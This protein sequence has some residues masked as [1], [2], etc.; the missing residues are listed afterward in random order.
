VARLLAGA[1]LFRIFRDDFSE[2]LR[3]AA[4][5]PTGWRFSASLRQRAFHESYKLL[6]TIGDGFVVVHFFLPRVG[7]PPE[8]MCAFGSGWPTGVRLGV[9][10]QQTL[11]DPS[12]MRFFIAAAALLFSE[13]VRCF[14]VSS[15][16]LADR[17]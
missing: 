11:S 5:H 12:A 13:L 3:A 2:A 9:V 1:F 14:I 16:E 6:D 4:R 8:M 15:R 10:T 7:K 17:R